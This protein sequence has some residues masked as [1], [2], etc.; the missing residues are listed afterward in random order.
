MSPDLSK[1]GERE[2]HDVSLPQPG[3]PWL[4]VAWFIGATILA[5]APVQWIAAAA[6]LWMGIGIVFLL[7]HYRKWALDVFAT[8]LNFASRARQA[9]ID[10]ANRELLQRSED[11]VGRRKSV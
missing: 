4:A 8:Y 10:R 3:F 9:G 6:F 5:F 11:E 2:F 7:E 1:F